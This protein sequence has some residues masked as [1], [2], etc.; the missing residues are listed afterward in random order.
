MWAKQKRSGFTIV[1]LLIVIVVIAILAAI[2]II[3]Y[4]GITDRAGKSAATAALSE[5]IKKV[6]LY[7][8]DHNDTYPG[9]LTAAGLTN[10][11][12]T[13]YRYTAYNGEDPKTYCITAIHKST[14]VYAEG[15]QPNPQDGWCPGH[16]DDATFTTNL[17]P[18]PGFENNVDGWEAVGGATI[19]RVSEQADGGQYSLKITPHPTNATTGARLYTKSLPAESGQEY[20]ATVRVRTTTP[21]LASDYVAL[22]VSTT[23]SSFAGGGA[24]PSQWRSHITFHTPGNDDGA[25]I[26]V[27]YTYDTVDGGPYSA[28]TP[29][30][31]DT[32]SFRK[33]SSSGA[34]A[35]R[36]GASDSWIWNGIPGNSTSTGPLP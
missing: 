17:V 4:N 2:T 11:E 27:I 22:R 14:A 19:E 35:F 8:V 13:N 18:N 25:T 23:Y 29:F 36:D 7:A 16:E 5:A 24:S 1:E 15:L 20:L 12:T 9:S 6:A 10:S 26:S 28:R 34:T 3:A 21:D 32:V 33:Q 30:Y 31:I